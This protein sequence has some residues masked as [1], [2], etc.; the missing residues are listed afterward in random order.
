MSEL[1][2]K[3]KNSQLDEKVNFF[4]TNARNEIFKHTFIIDMYSIDLMIATYFEYFRVFDELI[5][6]NTLCN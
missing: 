6:K 5:S 1:I 2:T 3:P 4:R